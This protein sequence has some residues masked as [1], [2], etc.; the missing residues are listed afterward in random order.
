M[1]KHVVWEQRDLGYLPL[2]QEHQD[3]LGASLPYFWSRELCISALVASQRSWTPPLSWNLF[4]H[5]ANCTA[6]PTR[7]ISALREGCCVR[8]A[9]EAGSLSDQHLPSLASS[10]RS[11]HLWAKQAGR[12][13]TCE[14]FSS[15][16]C[17]QPSQLPHSLQLRP[18]SGGVDSCCGAGVLSVSVFGGW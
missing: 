2:I 3:P 13:T 16:L 1:Y 7:A 12:H 6:T 9:C 10:H 4:S 5:L 11:T 15:R 14:A 18:K 17:S 8:R